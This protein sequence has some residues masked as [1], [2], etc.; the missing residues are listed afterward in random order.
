MCHADLDLERS[1]R[2]GEASLIEW[3]SHQPGRSIG[4]LR[5]GFF[6]RAEL[7]AS[8]ALGSGLSKTKGTHGLRWT[9]SARM[10]Q[11]SLYTAMKSRSILIKLTDYLAEFLPI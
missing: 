11:D 4:S 7:A 6:D 10:T 3:S 2:E 5:Q 1:E 8:P 9:S